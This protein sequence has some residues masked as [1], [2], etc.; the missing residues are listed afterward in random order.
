MPQDREQVRLN[1]RPNTIN[2]L[3]VGE[4]PPPSGKTFFY[5]GNS[6]LF[7]FWKS[8]FSEF[9]GKT[10]SSPE[11]FLRWFQEQGCYLDDFLSNPLPK[12]RYAKEELRN[13]LLPNSVSLF[14]K[15]LQAFK[16]KVV[17]VVIKS[18]DSYVHKAIV[19]SELE[20]CAHE[21]VGF[22]YIRGGKICPQTIS[23]AQYVLTKLKQLNLIDQ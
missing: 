7:D 18:I 6:I 22:P 4:S 2:V 11:S 19:K 9:F 12:N 20:I 1:Y 13:I 10:W 5:A 3:F 16:P 21:V 14:A 8:V 15:K 23:E 17:I